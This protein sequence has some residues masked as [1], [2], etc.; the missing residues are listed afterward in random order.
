[1]GGLTLKCVFRETEFELVSGGSGY[2]Q[3][4]SSCEHCNEQLGF[5]FCMRV[6]MRVRE[7]PCGQACVHVYQLIF[8]VSVVL[9]KYKVWISQVCMKGLLDFHIIFRRLF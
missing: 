6:C 9:T 3:M 5:K 7:Y 8:K 1:M 2:G 4:A